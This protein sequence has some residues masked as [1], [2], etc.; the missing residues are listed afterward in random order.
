VL[1]AGGCAARQPAGSAVPAAPLPSRSP[2]ATALSAAGRRALAGRYLAIAVPANRRLETEVAGFADHRRHDLAAAESDLRAE[3][4][5]ERWFDR[6]LAEIG[7][8]AAIAPVA[9]ALIAAN[10]HRIAYTEL[11]ARC[12]TIAE[13]RAFASGHRA[14]DA[15]VEAR[16]RLIR[17]ALRL[18][19]LSE[20]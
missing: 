7:F 10:Q 2:A 18:P 11:E 12:A 20:S 13:L 14:A 15:A 19:P 1:V 16:V 5:T 9:G 8:P 4:G 6:R 3:A 17:L